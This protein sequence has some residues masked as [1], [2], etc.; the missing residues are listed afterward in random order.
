MR[1]AVSRVLSGRGAVR[2]CSTFGLGYHARACACT[3]TPP[4]RAE[5]RRASPA[6]RHTH[7]LF[8]TTRA[9]GSAVGRALGRRALGRRALGR[10]ALRHP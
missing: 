3:H 1:E 4:L 2:A 6:M 5:P 8:C 7:H 9:I 10:R